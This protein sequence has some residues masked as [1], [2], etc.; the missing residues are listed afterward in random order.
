MRMGAEIPRYS[1]EKLRSL[2]ARRRLCDVVRETVPFISDDF[3]EAVQHTSVCILTDGLVG[4][5][6][7][8]FWLVARYHRIR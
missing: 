5:E 3:A 8:I 6:L 4:L 1:L 2:L 7:P